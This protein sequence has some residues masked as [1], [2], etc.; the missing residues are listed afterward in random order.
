MLF[1]R[2]V[3]AAGVVLASVLLGGCGATIYTPRPSPRI[4]VVPD[5]SQIVLVKNGHR[6]ATGTLGGAVEEAV[7]GNPQ[8]E[9]EAREYRHRGIAGFILSTVGSVTAGVGAGVLIGNEFQ[10]N[11]SDG[12]RDASIGMTIGGAVLS[13]VGSFIVSSAQPHLWNAINIYNDSL[14]AAYPVWAP[15]SAYPG[16][17]AAPV[18]PPPGAP[19]PA[20]PLAPAPPFA[21][22]P[23]APAPPPP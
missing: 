15:R 22:A 7:E 12:L 10:Q 9:E 6:Y 18:P 5:G 4:Q 23:P 16:Y 17:P 20:V 13:L 21:P 3:C 14:P 11:P 19:F 2:R 1:Q 8:A